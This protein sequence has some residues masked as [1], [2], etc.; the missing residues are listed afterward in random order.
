MKQGD[1]A[2]V[3]CSHQCNVLIMTDTNF[4]NYKNGRRYRYYGGFYNRLPAQISVPNTDNWNI[5]LD[6]GG[7]SANIRHSIRIIAA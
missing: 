7:R 1:C 3:D 2:L 6:L 4:R 5:V